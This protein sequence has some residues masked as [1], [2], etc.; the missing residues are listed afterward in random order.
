M[1]VKESVKTQKMEE[2]NALK[3]A[4]QGRE[5]R[6]QFI[7]QVTRDRKQ[8]NRTSCDC[9]G[10]WSFGDIG[11]EALSGMYSRAHIYHS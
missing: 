8:G 7:T 4:E 9:E 11:D 2:R 3:E 5:A 1:I 10:D 6:Q